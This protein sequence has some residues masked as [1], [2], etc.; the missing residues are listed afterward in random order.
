MSGTSRDASGQGLI[1]SGGD[2]HEMNN[3]SQP[4]Q[5]NYLN[6][7]AQEYHSTRQPQYQNNN[8]GGGHV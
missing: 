8:Y 6:A 3:Y 1:N 2:L 5:V 7:A 4:S